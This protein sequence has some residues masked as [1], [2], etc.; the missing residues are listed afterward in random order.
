M[1]GLMTQL[2]QIIVIMCKIRTVLVKK[3][4]L[5]TYICSI[6]TVILFPEQRKTI[7]KMRLSYIYI[8]EACRDRG[9]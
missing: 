2:G 4:T 8:E 6:C 9:I 3:S 1:I 7:I 5:E